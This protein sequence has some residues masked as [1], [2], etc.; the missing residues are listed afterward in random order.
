MD[1][2]SIIGQE[3][4]KKIL[5]NSVQ[6]HRISHAQ[7]LVG[8]DGYGVLP[9]ALAY[10][11]EIFLKENPDSGHKI[12]N[13]NHLDLHFSFPIY[14]IKSKATTFSKVESG[15]TFQHYW[16]E[17]VKQNPYVSFDDWNNI[18]DAQNKQLFISADEVEEITEK[19]SLK[20]FEGG[21]K[22][23]IIWHAD[24]MNESASNKLLK[25]LE[26][27]PARTIIL[28]LADKTDYILPTILSRCQTIEVPKI[29]SDTLENYLVNNRQLSPESAK[30]IV[31][32]AQ[33]DFNLAEKLIHNDTLNEEFEAL[34]IEW[35][36]SA[37][38]AKKKPAVL[39]EII[40]WART[41]A[42]WNREKQK[43]FIEYATEIF[44]LA[45]LQNYGM[46]DLV[47]QKLEKN[48]FK[49]EG[50]AGYIHGA[51]IEA[52]LE[53]LNTANLHIYRNANAK[54]VWTDMGI[55]LTRYIHKSTE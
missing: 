53:E 44:R 55:K 20:S 11:K 23:I 8:K 21:S 54:I 18:L 50:F 2:D 39:K 47:Y 4:I 29:N 22:V 17:M 12:D 1:W 3:N 34:F 14:S 24:K 38:Q 28:L 7:L 31:Y 33:G 13:F 43:S 48:G 15:G 27:P 25:F 6:E 37:F 32:Q 46:Q 10:A 5:Q 42:N 41:V 51:N 35:V 45:L 40:Q 49:W 16:K 36:R 30:K 52:I 9:L 19:F 26:E